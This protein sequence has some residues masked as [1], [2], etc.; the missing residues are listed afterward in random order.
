MV[1]T[2]RKAVVSLSTPLSE[3]STVRRGAVHARAL[4]SVGYCLPQACLGPRIEIK[5]KADGGQLSQEAISRLHPSSA[6][7]GLQEGEGGL[8]GSRGA[9]AEAYGLQQQRRRRRE[10]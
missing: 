6:G 4:E 1:E 9:M 10:G 7:K 2:K 8:L 3:N 5:I